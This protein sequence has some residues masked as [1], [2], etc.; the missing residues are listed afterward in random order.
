MSG[1]QPVGQRHARASRAGQQ[2]RCGEEGTGDQGA[3]RRR[4]R[5]GA[6][7]EGAAKKAPEKAAA[8]KAPAKKAPAA[9]AAA[10]KTAEASDE[11]KEGS[12]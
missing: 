4:L 7:Q 11:A 6:G 8:K 5:D 10:K 1:A 12:E 3:S 9:K 2:G